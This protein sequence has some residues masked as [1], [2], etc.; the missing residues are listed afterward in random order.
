METK[1]KGTFL[2]L[3]ALGRAA[4]GQQ[5]ELNQGLFFLIGRWSRWTGGGGDGAV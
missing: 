3:F 2:L 1:P 4:R 5:L